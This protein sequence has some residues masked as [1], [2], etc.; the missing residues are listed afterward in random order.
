MLFLGKF[1]VS[2]PAPTRILKYFQ[3][4][5]NDASLGLRMV[6]ETHLG[7]RLSY[8]PRIAQL[9]RRFLSF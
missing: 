4:A 1:K 5:E 8:G 9:G 6:W 7:R 3:V 2:S